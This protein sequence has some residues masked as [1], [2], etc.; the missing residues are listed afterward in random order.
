MSR[1]RA[2]D[3]LADVLAAAADRIAEAHRAGDVT[4]HTLAIEEVRAVASALRYARSLA[5]AARTAE[6]MAG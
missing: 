4:R 3:R 2:Q 5:D 6:V 1:S